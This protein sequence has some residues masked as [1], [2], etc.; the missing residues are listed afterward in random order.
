MEKHQRIGF[1]IILVIGA[2]AIL[3]IAAVIYFSLAGKTTKDTSIKLSPTPKPSITTSSS[4]TPAITPSDN[5]IIESEAANFVKGFYESY[6]ISTRRIEVIQHFGT[7]KLQSSY[8]IKDSMDPILCSK[9]YPSGFE[10]V[11]TTVKGGNAEVLVRLKLPD[12]PNE[13]EIT[14]VKSANTIKIDSVK[15][16][17]PD[18]GKQ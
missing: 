12:K 18:T 16:P 2:M 6:S 1:S 15:C 10:T 4:P 3:M 17:N 8:A 5:V 9:Q 13:I 11:S 14:A 7:S